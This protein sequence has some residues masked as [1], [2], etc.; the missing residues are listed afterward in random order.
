[1]P[2]HATL[3]AHVALISWAK[4]EE[5]TKDGG[6]MKKCLKPS[7]EYKTP[8]PESKVT[9]RCDW[10]LGWAQEEDATSSSASPQQHKWWLSLASKGMYRFTLLFNFTIEK[11][12][13]ALPC[14]GS[15][16]WLITGADN[17]INWLRLTSLWWSLACTGI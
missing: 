16:F 6:I 1:M 5:V 8:G 2:P 14:L 4:V 15:T 10:R 9:I 13:H 17:A 11:T 12:T 7:T 3:E